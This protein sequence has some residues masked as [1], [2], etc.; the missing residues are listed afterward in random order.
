MQ[1]VTLHGR[2]TERDFGDTIFECTIHVFT[3]GV[4]GRLVDLDRVGDQATIQLVAPSRVYGE[5]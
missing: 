5:I 1:L 4:I 2:V 3:T